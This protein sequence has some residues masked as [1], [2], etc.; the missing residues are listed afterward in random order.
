MLIYSNADKSV[1]LSVTRVN[2]GSVAFFNCVEVTER[3]IH[4][5]PPR[6][7]VISLD[8]GLLVAV[9]HVATSHRTSPTWLSTDRESN[10]R[11]AG[12]L[13]IILSIQLPYG[14]CTL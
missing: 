6:P 13:L 12:A 3:V 9:V 8:D 11:E 10:T 5:V 14:R 4:V 2:Q 1:E 7:V